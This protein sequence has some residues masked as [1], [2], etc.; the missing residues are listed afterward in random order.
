MESGVPQGSV[1]GPTLFLYYINYLP[2]DLSSTVRLFADDT[3]CHKITESACDHDVLQR[4]LDRMS[5]GRKKWLI[6][7]SPE[8]CQALHFTT[9]MNPL[10][11]P[12]HPHGHILETT[13]E[14]NYLGVTIPND[15][16]WDTHVSKI[17]K[18]ASK[19][20]GFLRR[21]LKLGFISTKE[22]AYKAIVRPILENVSPVWGPHTAN[23]NIGQIE[24][25]F[26]GE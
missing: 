1:L 17:S 26:S 14:T 16:K 9:K 2:K 6:S 10:R 3:L 21:N 19:T 12:Y 20:L 23:H 22:L 24:K 25:K 15:L 11:A 13:E 7:F 18:K 5:S 8:K 4:D